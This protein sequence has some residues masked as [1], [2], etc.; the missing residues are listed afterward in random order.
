MIIVPEKDLKKQLLRVKM[1]GRYVGGEFGII[2]KKNAPYKITLCFP[3]LYEIGM[4]N[5]A[6]KILYELINNETQAS[7]ERVFSPA[8]DF[9]E[10]LRK[11]SINL[12]T[13]ESGSSIKD[14]DLLAFTVGYE[15]SATNILNVINLSNIPLKNNERTEADPIIIA[16]GPAVTNPLPFSDFIDVFFIGEAEE[17]FPALIEELAEMK[18]TGCKRVELLKKIQELPFIWHSNKK[19]KVEKTVWSNFEKQSYISARIVPSISVVQDHGVVEIMRGCPNGCRFCHAGIFYRPYREKSVKTIINEIDNLIYRCGYREITLSSLSTG[20]YS[21]IKELITLLNKKYA[22]EKISFSLPSIRVNSLTL[23]IISEIS[24][25]RK[26][27]LTFAVETPEIEKQRGLNKEAPIEKIIEILNEA[28]KMGWNRAKF[29]FMIGLPFFKKDDETDLIIDFLRE[30]G[31]RTRMNLN[32]N[33]GTFI[34]KPHTPFQWSFQLNEEIAFERIKKIK[35]ALPS[36]F[37]KLGYQSPNMSFIEGIISRGDER[38]GELLLSV[39]KKGARLDAWEEYIDKSAWKETIDNADWDIETEI[40]TSKNTDMPL[41]W[42]NISLNVG[43]GFLQTEWEKTF[44]GSLTEPCSDSC[45]HKCGACNS[46]NEVKINKD[47]L[48]IKNLLDEAENNKQDINSFNQLKVLFSFE[49]KGKAIFL[50][51]INIMTVLERALIRAGIQAVYSSG[52]NPKPKLEFANP[53]TLGFS[54]NEEIAG[55]EIYFNKEKTNDEVQ[56]FFID[57]LNSVLPMGLRITKAKVV[58]KIL[59]KKT[60]KKVNS[61]MSTYYGSL[62]EIISDNDDVYRR[63]KKIII[64]KNG[65]DIIREDFS[66]RKLVVKI[67]VY[68]NKITNLFKFF[69]EELLL[70]NPFDYLEINRLFTYA[71][72]ENSFFDF[73]K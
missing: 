14:S 41:P 4:S 5:Q 59:S 32:V 67:I 46:I 47:E 7:C 64:Q 44:S 13:L 9:E 55:V 12:Y 48:F 25:V 38:V 39:F 11:E 18:K 29:Y 22:E 54:S 19:T 72:D 16:G 49:K 33:I 53:L 15:L 42:D 58:N 60:G 63:L 51:H 26:S 34:P 62:F 27:G 50:S 37:F 65:I 1:P 71:I 28:K 66:E 35:N 43:N 68:E 21:N 45:N 52:F 73:Y 23:P 36:R 17:V 8:P 10:I 57:G 30:V 70:E 31:R 61:L 3:D 20:D 69:K 40:N 6:L 2:Q 24:R 56:S